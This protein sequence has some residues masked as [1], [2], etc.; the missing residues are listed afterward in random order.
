MEGPFP[1]RAEEGE[2]LLLLDQELF[3]CNPS[4]GQHWLKEHR[5]AATGWDAEAAVLRGGRNLK[6]CGG[7]EEMCFEGT[8]KG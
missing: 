7:A 4:H 2:T 5:R 3:L 6:S 8:G 1:M